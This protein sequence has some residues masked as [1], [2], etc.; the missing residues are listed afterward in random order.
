MLARA[1]SRLASKSSKRSLATASAGAKSQ[2]AWRKLLLAGAATP[3]AL[4]FLYYQAGLSMQER[5][6]VR[7]N[8]DSMWR[9]LRSFSVG[10]RI[11]A[12]YK[13]NV[14]NPLFRLDD[15][16]DTYVRLIAGCHQRAAELMV[17]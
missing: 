7:A 17:R 11:A 9:A 15:N 10:L 8:L 1:F 5:R 16:S 14:Y 3:S 12:D 4:L 2:R 13:W 6:R